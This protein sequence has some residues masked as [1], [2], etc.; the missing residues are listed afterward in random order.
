MQQPTK[1]RP[2][3]RAAGTVDVLL[4]SGAD[5]T[6]LDDEGKAAVAFVSKHDYSE[7]FKSEQRARDLLV[8]AAGL[9]GVA[10]HPP[11]SNAASTGEQQRDPPHGT[12]DSQRGE[13]GH[14]RLR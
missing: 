7:L 11:R 5:E 3:A 10:L 2:K 9:T 12:T 13:N 6:I 4:R 8:H 1:P 14:D